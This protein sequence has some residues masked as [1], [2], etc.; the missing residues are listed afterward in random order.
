MLSLLQVTR[1][2][3]RAG[4]ALKCV[5]A[6]W[7]ERTY[8]ILQGEAPELKQQVL[9]AALPLVP[10]YGWTTLC[11]SKGAETI[12]VN[13]MV[14]G[15]CAGGPAD[16]IEYFLVDSGKNLARKLDR[17]D[18]QR[19]GARLNVTQ[20]IRAGIVTRLE[21]TMPY[22]AQWP[23]ALAIMGSTLEGKMKLIR[24]LGRLS[25]EIWYQAGDRSTDFNW[26]SKRG[27]LAALYSSSELFMIQDKSV[28]FADTMTFL[29]HRLKDLASISGLQAEVGRGIMNIGHHASGLLYT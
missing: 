24:S 26:Y 16:L 12:G 28:S 4:V 17:M 9:A 18:L 14:N 19:A 1:P 27:T 22:V 5:Q 3:V 15:L 6:L 25:D 13:A 20:R 7:H 29:D 11:I 21:L 23:Q 10:T 2:M 8:S